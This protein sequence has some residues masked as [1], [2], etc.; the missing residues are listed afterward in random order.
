M[1][2][3]SILTVLLAATTLAWAIRLGRTSPGP[4]RSAIA[5]ASTPRS[6]SRTRSLSR[7]RRQQ[8]PRRDPARRSAAGQFQSALQG[9]VACT[10]HGIFARSSHHC[11]RRDRL[12]CRELHRYRDQLREARKLCRALTRRSLRQTEK[13]SSRYR[14]AGDKGISIYSAAIDRRVAGH[15]CLLSS[16]KV[17]VL[18]GPK[19]AS[20]KRVFELKSQNMMDGRNNF[21]VAAS[22]PLRA[23]GSTTL[24]VFLCC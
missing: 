7:P 14:S 21:A 17:S 10:R 15:G 18:L 9:P 3:S 12:E 11:C 2:R 4:Y 19:P 22:T 1:K 20:R 16:C 5:I 23:P 6:S 13:R 8:A 24:R